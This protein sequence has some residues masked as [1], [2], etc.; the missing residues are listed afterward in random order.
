MGFA[1][2]PLPLSRARFPQ[3]SPIHRMNHFSSQKISMPKN[4]N[5]MHKRKLW[6]F[7]SVQGSQSALWVFSLCVCVPI[8]CQTVYF[9]HFFLAAVASAAYLR[10]CACVLYVQFWPHN[11]Y[12]EIVFSD[13]PNESNA[14]RGRRAWKQSQIMVSERQLFQNFQVKLLFFIPWFAGYMTSIICRIWSGWYS[15]GFD[16]KSHY[17]HSLFMCVCVLFFF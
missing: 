9:H 11:S 12:Y 15:I 1:S 5:N 16:R 13:Q 4:S 2:P 10:V 17:R 14:E 3:I 6:W 7:F 8:L